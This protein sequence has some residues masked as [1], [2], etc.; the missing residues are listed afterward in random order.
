[1]KLLFSPCL[2]KLI[3]GFYCPGCGGS[4]AVLALIHGH[5]IS[6]F[7]YHPLVEYSLVAFLYNLIRMFVNKKYHPKAL[8]LWMALVI[9]IVNWIVKDLALFLGYDL[10]SLAEY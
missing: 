8:W 1:M 7:I 4:R 6:S 3:T 9:V 10:M 2:F 5:L